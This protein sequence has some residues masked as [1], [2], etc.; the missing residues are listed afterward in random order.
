MELTSKVLLDTYTEKIS[1][2]FDY[3]FDGVSVFKCWDV[4]NIVNED[5]NIGLVV[6]SSGSGKSTLLNQIRPIRQNTWNNDISIASHFRNPDEA[7]DKLS[8]VGLNSIPSWVKP[9]NAL[10]NGEKFRADLAISLVDDAVID[11]F[12]SVV[13]REV[14]LACSV[15]VSKYIRKNNIKRIIFASCHR[16][17]IDWLD[18]DWIFDTD[19]GELTNRRCLRQRPSINIEI[20]ECSR[21]AW[22][23]F[24]KHHYLNNEMNN[25]SRCYVGL[26]DNK[27]I[28]FSANLSLPS[29]IPPLFE[30]D[31]RNKFRESRLV[32][33]PDYQG[34][35]VGTRFSDA[36]GELFLKNDYRY[37]S[38]TAHIRMGEYRQ[39]SNLWRPTSTNLKSRE[40]SQKCSKKEAWH[41]MMLDTR[42][43]CYSHEYI[44]N[45]QNKYRILYENYKNGKV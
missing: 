33:L 10:S 38:K 11:E 1:R 17:I 3:D 26:W 29:K 25:A 36:I 20:F 4:P 6:G 45:M 19:S 5:Y 12:T 43:L 9:Y 13:D 44:G 42:R 34:M 30:G 15:A 32:V 35:G 14:A 41:H 16:D 37:F 28:V 7:I 21:T 22:K 39:K 23:L 40:K 2:V 27:P 24:R 31:N 18:P 8:A